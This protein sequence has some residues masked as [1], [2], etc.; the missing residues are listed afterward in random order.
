MQDYLR[1]QSPTRR[2]WTE[3]ESSSGAWTENQLL[4]VQLS[5]RCHVIMKKQPCM[6]FVHDQMVD[7]G[8]HKKSLE[9]TLTRR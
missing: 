3:N 9:H 6:S 5:G 7:D 2:M 8:Y 1:V 4:Y